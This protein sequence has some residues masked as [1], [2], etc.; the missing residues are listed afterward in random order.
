MERQNLAV[1]GLFVFHT[2][3]RGSLTFGLLCNSS[4]LGDKGAS[5]ALIDQL[6]VKNAFSLQK[7]K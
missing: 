6:G 2:G 4:V 3:A 1:I 5:T 7:T